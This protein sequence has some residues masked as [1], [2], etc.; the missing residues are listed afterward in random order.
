MS[1]TPRF[2][3]TDFLFPTSDHH[4]TV[5]MEE[6][7]FPTGCSTWDL[8]PA[9][10]YVELQENR[11]A[12]E[13]KGAV[14]HDEVDGFRAEEWVLSQNWLPTSFAL[15]TWGSPHVEL[16]DGRTSGI[17]HG[18]AK[19][20]KLHVFSSLRKQFPQSAILV[21][22]CGHSITSHDLG[23][24]GTWLMRFQNHDKRYTYVPRFSTGWARCE[25]EDVMALVYL[26]PK[27]EERWETFS[28]SNGDLHFQHFLTELDQGGSFL[29]L[30]E[31]RATLSRI[32]VEHVAE[33]VV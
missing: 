12:M 7:K 23:D 6:A 22:F 25:E 26:P 11:R 5:T 14:F 21:T 10:A 2:V 3:V 13:A 15:V 31:E 18:H 29:F 1:A 19:V 17:K 33:G 28:S 27:L 16:A 24:T 9:P 8:A 4:S 30:G 20:Q 32:A